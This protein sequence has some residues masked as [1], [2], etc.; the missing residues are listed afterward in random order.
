MIGYE[1]VPLADRRFVTIN[2]D[3]TDEHSERLSEGLDE[4]DIVAA[5]IATE[6]P[7]TD[8]V[9]RIQYRATEEQHRRVDHAALTALLEDAGVHRV[10][11]GLQWEPVRESRARVQGVDEQLAPNAAVRAW[12]VANDVA[13]A[14]AVALERLTSD[15]LEGV[16][17]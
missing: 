4:T 17:R 8:A 11:G 12:C 7:L 13:D 5:H 3:L 1:F 14:P 15:Y 6:I 9:V 2:V 16:A 10:Y